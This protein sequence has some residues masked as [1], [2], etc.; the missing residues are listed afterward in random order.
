MME[1]YLLLALLMIHKPFWLNSMK[2][3]GQN[4]GILLGKE[5]L[6]VMIAPVLME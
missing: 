5:G 6:Q 3:M 4:F 1:I 2:V